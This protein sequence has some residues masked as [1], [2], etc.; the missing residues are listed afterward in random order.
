MK[1]I[2]IRSLRRNNYL[3]QI[4]NAK[5]QTKLTTKSY[6]LTVW[7]GVFGGILC[8]LKTETHKVKTRIQRNLLVP[9]VPETFHAPF[10]VSVK[11]SC[12]VTRAKSIFW[13]SWHRPC[14]PEATHGE[15]TSGIQGIY[16]RICSYNLGHLPSF[17]YSN[18][19]SK[20]LRENKFRSCTSPPPSLKMF[21]LKGNI[22]NS[23]H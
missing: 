8:K 6:K 2:K 23:F 4:N 7:V 21:D 9:W 13:R 20:N 5:Y 17:P 22:K 3:K 16:A 11:S 10:P 14:R 12:L 15:K 1:D 19:Q 18:S